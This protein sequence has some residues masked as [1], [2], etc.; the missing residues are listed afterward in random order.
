MGSG[1]SQPE[2]EQN[3]SRKETG[4]FHEFSY[5]RKEFMEKRG[6]KTNLELFDE[7]QERASNGKPSMLRQR[8]TM[9][10]IT[11]VRQT[12]NESVQGSPVIGGKIVGFTGSDSDL[13]GSKIQK[14][15]STIG[16]SAALERRRRGKI[17]DRNSKSRRKITNFMKQTK[18]AAGYAQRAQQD[19]QRKDAAGIVMTAFRKFFFVGSD[20]FDRMPLIFD[21]IEPLK[22]EA[23]D[24][25]IQKGEEGDKMY[26]IMSG[27]LDVM[28]DDEET[29]KVQLF[30]GDL[31]GEVALVYNEKR[32]ATVRVK[33]GGML[34]SLSRASYKSLQAMA[35][36]S[37]IV[38]RCTWLHNVAA[39]NQVGYFAVSRIAQ[40][41]CEVKTF[42]AGEVILKKGDV[43]TMCIMVED[44]EVDV[45]AGDALPQ[46]L[47]HFVSP[48]E[49]G[50]ISE[51]TKAVV[52]GM[53]TF[54]GDG[55]LMDAAG[56]S[57]SWGDNVSPVT[58]TTR[59][60][61]TCSL[62]NVEEIHACIGSTE[63]KNLNSLGA[64]SDKDAEVVKYTLDDFK[65][66]KFLGQGSFGAV[67]LVEAVNPAPGSPPHYALKRLGKHFLA[68][69]GQIDHTLQERAISITMNHPL[70]LKMYATFQSP[71]EVYFL[72]EYIEGCDLWSVIHDD[73][74]GALLPGGGLPNEY[75]KFY[76]AC[77]L[78]AVRH[79]HSHGIAFRDLKPEN[80]MLGSDG[81]VKLIDF[82]FAKK[83]PYSEPLESGG[84]QLMPKSHTMCGTPE[85]LA[86]EFITSEG[87]DHT[88][89]L[90]AC[91]VI[92]H[93]LV[94]STSPFRAPGQQANMTV[95]FTAI[96]TTM[97]TGLKLS[98]HFH[99]RAGEGMHDLIQKLCQFRPTMRLGGGPRGVVE[100]YEHPAY[101]GYD[102]EALV[103]KD[104]E[105]P[106]KP[107]PDD[108]DRLR[109]EEEERQVEEFDGDQEVF[110]AFG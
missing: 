53:G 27:V 82:G 18:S 69:C 96:V 11:Y 90:W 105:A 28:M 99:E 50:A 29:V 42:E 52:A 43:T 51:E 95:L 6:N 83:I 16:V 38:K 1:A 7:I 20:L 12:S 15:N 37:S 75:V 78:A 106:W 21:A 3:K 57:T 13:R 25:L 22:V 103:M 97:Y 76:S 46:G 68:T 19:T 10:D 71:S 80:I 104:V 60:K 54:I 26:V 84:F 4:T 47:F 56:Q 67:T 66:V 102:F 94:T 49:G 9:N 70:V 63:L 101:A 5:Y 8:G 65:L 61:V 39:L 2:Q 40:T 31:V 100:V 41:C 77:I 110:A 23:G 107:N 36:T 73:A 91:G 93:E 85:Y 108:M 59:G 92:F 32:M 17:W 45:D 34:F 44:G 98:D 55:I 72:S 48:P 58:V 30:H 33:E 88:C 35:S 89:D 24:V 81:Y 64:K 79:V 109:E 14:F 74:T 62:L 86:P 87:H